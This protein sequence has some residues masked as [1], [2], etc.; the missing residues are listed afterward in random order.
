[1][2]KTPGITD[3]ELDHARLTFGKYTGQTPSQVSEKDP[4]YIVWMY[5][6][7]TNRDTCSKLLRDECAK[8]PKGKRPSTQDADTPL[9]DKIDY[10]KSNPY[11]HKE[12][13]RKFQNDFDD[14]IPF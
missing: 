11:T 9:S 5:D 3:E 7:V 6:N 1:M 8:V 4:Q 13:R 14:D 12:L 2:P 10:Y